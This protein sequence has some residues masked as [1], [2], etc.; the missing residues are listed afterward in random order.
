MKRMVKSKLFTKKEKPE[1]VVDKPK[2]V[3]SLFDKVRDELKVADSDGLVLYQDGDGSIPTQEVG[4]ALRA[5]MTYPSVSYKLLKTMLYY[6][7]A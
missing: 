6:I 5:M 3:F 7:L 1:E 2:E 4:T